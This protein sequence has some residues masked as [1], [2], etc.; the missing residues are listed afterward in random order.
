MPDL[1]R[2]DAVYFFDLYVN[3]NRYIEEGNISFE[4]NTF[5]N[6]TFSTV[7]KWMEVRGTL[8]IIRKVKHYG[9]ICVHF[10]W[11]ILKAVILCPLGIWR[12]G[13]R[14]I[15]LVSERGTDARD[16]GYHFFRYLREQHPDIP[17]YYVISKDSP[18]RKRV[19]SL[20]NVVEYRSLKHY[21]L[22]FGAKYLVSSHYMGFTPARDFYMYIQEKSKRKILPG[23]TVFLQH[24][25]I[26]DDM[27][28][29][30]QEKTRLDLFI[31]G[32]R[33]EYDYI[34]QNWHYRKEEVQYTGLARFDALQ[35]FQ[36]KRQVLI[37]P[38]W[39]NWLIHSADASEKMVLESHYFCA[40]SSLLRN[41]KLARLARKYQVR[42]LF[43]PHYCV[44]PYLSKFETA[45]EDIVLADFAHYDVQQLLKESMLLVTDYSSVFFD[46]AYMQKP[47]LH[48]QFDEA[49]YRAN[50]YAEGYFDYRRDG[51][52]EVVTEESELLELI[53][54]YLAEDCR[55]KPEYQQRIDG[56]FPLHDDKNCE[57]I[58][59]EIQKLK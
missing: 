35:D 29:L 21:Q 19:E 56:F 45:S 10:G 30:Y 44:Q 31:C 51:F 3:C 8:R 25:V 7:P 46:F 48:Y 38:T 33:P 37:M 39:R 12:Y 20:G 22:L 4:N 36:A 6:T 5:G 58:Y 11:E 14:K 32:A 9:K 13:K 28:D 47:M 59:R 49:E 41:P 2:E 43:Y 23:K 15:W 42:F 16:N 57:R 24:G 55:L 27:T 54:Q 53:E 40:W 18:D 17:C 34:R 26:K 1:R 50:H 52:G